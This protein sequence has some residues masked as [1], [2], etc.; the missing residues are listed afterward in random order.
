MINHLFSLFDSLAMNFYPK[1]GGFLPSFFAIPH[2][3]YI[4]FKNYKI[5]IC[6]ITMSYESCIYFENEILSTVR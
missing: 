4:S 3:A 5:Q 6:P 1:T 2:Y